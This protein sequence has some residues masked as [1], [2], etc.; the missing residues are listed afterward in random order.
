MGV[1]IDV[2]NECSAPLATAFAYADDY[3]NATSWLAG[4]QK[5][6]PVGEQDQGLGAVFDASMNVGTTLHST[7][8]VDGWVENELIS[9]DAVKGFKV[10]SVWNFE[11]IDAH[12][13][14][15]RAHI[16]YDLPGGLAGKALGKMIEPFVKMSVKHSSAALR[17]CIEA[18]AASA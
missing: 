9:F 2:A 12:T 17:K 7:I 15:I 13:T 4:I 3:R 1:D 11:A 18:A 16:H 6:E 10:R 5:F 8:K 14:R